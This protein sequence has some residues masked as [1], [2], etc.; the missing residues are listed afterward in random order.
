MRWISGSWMILRLDRFHQQ[1]AE[2]FSHDLNRLPFFD[3]E[4]ST[5]SF[6][7]FAVNLYIPG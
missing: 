7:R 2:L 3:K 5:D 1:A 4:G 6:P